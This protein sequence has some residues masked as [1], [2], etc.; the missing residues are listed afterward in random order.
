MALDTPVLV[1]IGIFFL[2]KGGVRR[3]R[4]ANI[5]KPR[6]RYIL[7]KNPFTSLI[8]RNLEFEEGTFQFTKTTLTKE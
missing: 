1:E 5:L 8:L 6:G 3:P 7:Q 4:G 2:H